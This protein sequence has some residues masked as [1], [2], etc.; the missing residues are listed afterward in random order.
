ME[1]NLGADAMRVIAIF[2]VLIIHT[3]PFSRLSQDIGDSFNLPTILNQASRFAVPMFFVFMGYFWALNA[4]LK[5]DVQ[6]QAKYSILKMSRMFLFWS[7]IYLFPT[8]PEIFVNHGLIGFIKVVYWNINAVLTDPVD[9]LLTGTAIHLWFLSS[10]IQCMIIAYL[11]SRLH[12]ERYLGGLAIILFFIALI[13]GPYSWLPVGF[14]SD[15]NYRN[16]P[17]FAFIFFYSGSVL[18]KCREILTLQ[19]L[20]ALLLLVGVASQFIEL[21]FLHNIWSINL[22]QDYVFSTY[23][24]GV[25]AAIYGL[26]S[27][28]LLN[29]SNLSKYSKFVFGVYAS[30][31]LFVNLLTPLDRVIGDGA[32]WS[33]LYF[34]FVLVASYMLTTK[35]FSFPTLKRYLM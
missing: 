11:I 23:F 25:G 24:L 15:F 17:F 14:E 13:T 1:R 32:I 35:I 20:G 5:N 8:N 31:M 33:F 29:N 21:Y 2:G 26:S 19:W 30:H 22:A 3:T 18:Y 7:A 16:G 4:Q 12:L 10:A 27:S 6:S 34:L 9:F 28:T